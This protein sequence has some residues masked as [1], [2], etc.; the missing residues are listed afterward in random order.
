[1]AVDGH[2]IVWLD[3]LIFQAA[4]TFVFDWLLLWA[5]AAVTK[6][7]VSGRRLL[8]AAAVGTVY[9]GLYVLSAQAL[10]PLYGLW[11]SVGAILLVSVGMLLI[12]FGTGPWH[13]FLHVALPFYGIGIVGAGAGTVASFV[14]GHDGAPDPIVGFLAASG[15]LL[16]VAEL[17]W[18]AVQRQLWRQSHRLPMEITFGDSGLKATALVDTGNRLR[19]PLTGDP[20]IVMEASALQPLLPDYLRSAVQQMAKGDLEAVTRLLASERWSA[21]FRIIPFSSVGRKHGLL[22]AFRPDKVQLAVGGHPI[23]VG[24]CVLGLCQGPLDP[25]GIYCALVH[26]EL[27]QDALAKKSGPRLKS[28]LAN[29]IG[30]PGSRERG[31]A[32]NVTPH[33]EM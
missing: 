25:D 17:G 26:P 3:I 9:Y 2:T 15:A 28:W 33:S 5:T 10:V 4:A 14:A 22:V 31:R 24:P 19:D 16:V 8:A 27:V 12:A 6:V 29:I 32:G 11:R 18:G 30:R 1:M 13:R 21:R 20:V 7:A 23:I